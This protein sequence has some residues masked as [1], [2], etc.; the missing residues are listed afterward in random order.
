[1]RPS[2]KGPG[3]PSPKAHHPRRVPIAIC[4]AAGN[5][6]DV[7]G[8]YLCGKLSSP[9]LPDGKGQGGGSLAEDLLKHPLV[10]RDAEDQYTGELIAYE[11]MDLHGLT[12]LSMQ[13]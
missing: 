4:I 9:N 1:V 8:L 7:V 10:T 11:E 13:R 5:E 12:N 2:G 6:I 3:D